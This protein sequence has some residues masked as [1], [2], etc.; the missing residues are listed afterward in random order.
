MDPRALRSKVPSAFE[1]D[2]IDGDAWIGVVPF[3]MT[4]VTGRGLPTLPRVSEF[5]ELNVRTYV[6]VDDRPGVYFFSLDAGSLLAVHAA[7]SLL[8]LPYHHAAM[9][10]SSNRDVVSYDSRR[11][12][13]ASTAELSAKYSASGSVSAPVEDSLEYFLTER[14]CLYNVDRKGRPYRLEIHHPPWA[15]QPAEAEL[16]CNTMVDAAG[17][18]LPDRPPLLHF[19]G[20][21]D[22]VAWPPTVL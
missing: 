17:L 6:R 20:R 9:H 16:A 14:Y 21:Q 7:R 2:V 15:L 11:Y 12:G 3:S 13:N 4:N 18:T 19:V 1:L 8:N 10:V 5:P 22:T